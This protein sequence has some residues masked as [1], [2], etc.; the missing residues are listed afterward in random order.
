MP[1]DKSLTVYSKSGKTL[2]IEN[3]PES[4]K[5]AQANGWLMAKP[6]APS[7]GNVPPTS[8]ETQF[9]KQNKM[10]EN[11][12]FTPGNI[13]QN[14]WQGGKEMVQGGFDMAKNLAATSIPGLPEVMQGMGKQDPRMA[15]LHSIIDPMKQEMYKGAADPN[16]VSRFG[17]G[18]AGALPM[19]GPWAGGLGEQAGK[20]DIGGAMAKGGTQ[21][22]LGELGGKAMEHYAPEARMARQT[23][24]EDTGLAKST[25]LGDRPGGLGKANLEAAKIK[26]QGLRD[27]WTQ[28]NDRINQY[29]QSQHVN[30][31]S[32]A[33]RQYTAKARSLVDEIE[34][35]PQAA[36]TKTLAVKDALGRINAAIDSGRPITWVEARTLLSELKNAQGGLSGAS[37]LRAVTNNIRDNF[38]VAIDSTA[39]NSGIGDQW[40]AHDRNYNHL[41]SMERGH[42]RI[43]GGGTPDQLE[44]AARSKP[45][46]ARF[47]GVNI[48][49]T[50]R[51][52]GKIAK[53]E[54]K[55]FDLGMKA[56]ERNI[57]KV[58]VPNPQSPW[59][60]PTQGPQGPA[61]PPEGGSTPPTGPFQQPGGQPP[62][63]GGPLS[64]LHDAPQLGAAQSTQVGPST[65][66]PGQMEKGIV[67]GLNQWQ[68]TNPPGA[69]RPEPSPKGTSQD[70]MVVAKHVKASNAALEAWKQM[71]PGRQPTLRELSEIM[72]HADA[73]QTQMERQLRQ[74]ETDVK[75]GGQGGP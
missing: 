71:N 55:S 64:G 49:G 46:L 63:G 38:Q 39:K 15:L 70:P 57:N 53:G 1:Q 74:S 75:R 25:A 40:K 8:A 58:N 12:G 60:P 43:T 67:E 27:A 26:L 2:N 28:M 32:A 29:M 7:K 22:A 21:Y 65:L 41:S 35:S 36:Q 33:L 16:P 13:A 52:V 68:R 3:T 11:M 19:I 48:G 61:L 9:E 42:A 20:G 5:A 24:K 34:R 18:L 62:T 50:S 72:R 31:N 14:V 54:L 6:Y 47:R 37:E 66:M 23:A 30:V 73:L 59:A 17:H 4:I 45:P 44:A 56:L 51:A 69:T 10:P